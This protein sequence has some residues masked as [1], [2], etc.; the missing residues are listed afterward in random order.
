MF[1]L[2]SGELMMI[3]LV[4][5]IMVG[6][7]K[8]PTFMKSVA[9]GLKEFRSA[10]NELR[11]QAGI[12][13]IMRDVDVRTLTTPQRQL[14]SQQSSRAP[15]RLSVA[16]L[17]RERPEDGVDIVRAR[18]EALKAQYARDAA[19]DHELDEDPFDDAED[20]GPVARE[21]FEVTST[22][23]AAPIED[24]ELVEAD[25]ADTS[26]DDTSGDSA[27]SSAATSAK[28]AVESVKPASADDPAG[29]TR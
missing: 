17:E 24:A 1:G 28:E 27:A 19:K 4:I 20:V 22:R 23:R 3:A 12:D 13:E 16:E 10:S 8:M 15:R 26:G 18:A 5:L 14:P 11:R 7:T 2:G 9:K 21:D 25:D 6:P 29:A